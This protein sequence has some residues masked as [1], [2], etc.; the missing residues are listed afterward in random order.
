M[1]KYVLLASYIVSYILNVR[2]TQQKNFL[3]INHVFNAQV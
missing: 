1:A 2:K 3:V